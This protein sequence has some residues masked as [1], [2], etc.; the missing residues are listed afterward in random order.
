ML[1]P[2]QATAVQFAELHEELQAQNSR[3]RRLEASAQLAAAELASTKRY[4]VALRTRQKAD[5]DLMLDLVR[6]A[7]DTISGIER[8]I[9]ALEPRAKR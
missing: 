7:N 4:Q 6:T 1:I 9:R 8:R 2:R 5:L 3:C